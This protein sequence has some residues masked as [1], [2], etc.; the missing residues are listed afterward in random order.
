M[1]ENRCK[2]CGKPLAKGMICYECFDGYRQRKAKRVNIP[3]IEMSPHDYQVLQD[4]VKEYGVQTVMTYL[5]SI[6]EERG[7][8]NGNV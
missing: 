3:A 1:E 6:V 5:G 7:K 4:L 8:E 2:I